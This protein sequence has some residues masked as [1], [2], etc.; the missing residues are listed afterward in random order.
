MDYFRLSSTDQRP[1][2]LQASAT[3]IDKQRLVV[4]SPVKQE[5]QKEKDGRGSRGLVS[6]KGSLLESELE[7]EEKWNK[8]QKVRRQEGGSGCVLKKRPLLESELEAEKKRNKS[9]ESQKNKGVKGGRGLV[10]EQSS[11][12]ESESETE[13]EPE[14]EKKTRMSRIQKKLEHAK[15]KLAA[16][17]KA[18]EEF[19]AGV[20]TSVGAAAKAN[21]TKEVRLPRMTLQDFINA[22]PGKLFS[23]RRGRKS[24]F[25][26]PDQEKQVVKF[27]S[28]R[29]ELGCGLNFPQLHD[30]LHE[31]MLRIKSLSPAV[32]TGLEKSG[33]RPPRNWV[34]RFMDRS[35]VVL[36]WAG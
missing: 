20:H 16:L 10:S 8:S 18:K 9:L 29:C 13:P 22:P 11:L 4:S 25:L 1:V 24:K 3:S 27:L 6:K 34:Y 32:M 33:Q 15:M 30:L 14:T 35:G 19:E 36:R 21:S 31:I 26:T 12:I 17:R 7:A 23:A 5:R 2:D 28:K